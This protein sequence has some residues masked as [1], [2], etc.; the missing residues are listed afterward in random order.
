MIRQQYI[1]YAATGSAL[2]P[3]RSVVLLPTNL[4]MRS[5]A[6]MT[7]THCIDV[8]TGFV[9]KRDAEFIRGNKREC[10]VV[11]YL[12]GDSI[13]LAALLVLADRVSTARELAHG[14][15]VRKSRAGSSIPQRYWV[16][17]DRIRNRPAVRAR[18]AP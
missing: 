9:L 1:R 16:F 14:W 15:V 5:D 13:D 6:A 2:N 12:I 17:S 3:S 10:Y 18:S 8:L 4:P 11:S 7:L